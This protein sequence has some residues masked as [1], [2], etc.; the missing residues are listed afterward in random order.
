MIRATLGID[1]GCSSSSR[2]SQDFTDMAADLS[3]V[4]SPNVDCYTVDNLDRRFR[5]TTSGQMRSLTGWSSAATIETKQN[6][7]TSGHVALGEWMP[8][9]RLHHGQ[10]DYYK[11]M[12][13]QFFDSAFWY[14]VPPTVL[15]DTPLARAGD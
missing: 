1:L 11:I 9:K 5:F 15:L 10:Y 14:V 3:E 13:L 7:F 6:Q 2:T 4:L 8:C 12:Q